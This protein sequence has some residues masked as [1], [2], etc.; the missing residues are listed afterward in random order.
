MRFLGNLFL[1]AVATV[2][3]YFFLLYKP[4]APLVPAPEP[5]RT[6]TLAVAPEVKPR[7]SEPEA[8]KADPPPKPQPHSMPEL[9]PQPETP[10]PEPEKKEP[11]FDPEPPAE[12]GDP[13][14]EEKGDSFAEAEKDAQRVRN[15]LKEIGRSKA[16]L[17]K[18]NKELSGKSKRG[19]E[20]IIKTRSE[21]IIE[22]ARA[23]GGRIL[24]I[25]KAGLNPKAHYFY[26]LDVTGTPKVV[27]VTGEAPPTLSKT[28][29]LLRFE[30]RQLSAPLRVLRRTVPN[31]GDIYQFVAIIPA[32]E[33]AVVI[34]RRNAS[35][36]LYNRTQAEK[37]TFDDVRAVEMDYVPLAGGG[38]DVRVLGFRFADGTRWQREEKS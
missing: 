32:R 16:L 28:R 3:S 13:K 19:F 12:R 11:E 30:Y 2:L 1:L 10:A 7:R 34:A 20:T 14:G 26:E 36:D 15:E 17:D 21:E 33:W 22:L 18:A 24:L 27:K 38:F 35:L 4:G 6:D 8:V 23:F 25:P 37:K 5:E 31:R 9:P 29:N